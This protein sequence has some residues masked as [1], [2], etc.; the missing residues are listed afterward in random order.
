MILRGPPTCVE[1]DRAPLT[2]SDGLL[3][4]AD[5]GWN[6][7]LGGSLPNAAP[8]LFARSVDSSIPVCVFSSLLSPGKVRGLLPMTPG[9]AGMLRLRTPSVSAAAWMAAPIATTSSGFTRSSGGAPKNASTRLRMSGM[10]V[11]PP[12]RMT[13]SNDVGERRASASASW[14]TLNERSMSGVTMWSRSRRVI[15]KT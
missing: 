6:P 12:T 5:P 15:V 8:G 11:E 13:L 14:V 2:P 7:K 1:F 10:R 9:G 3:G 4:G